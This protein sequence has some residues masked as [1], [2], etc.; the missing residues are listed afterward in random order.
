MAFDLKR[1]LKVMLLASSGPLSVKDSQTAFAR[2]HEQAT[3]LPLTD[4]SAA[5]AAPGETPV[6]GESAGALF[7]AVEDEKYY[8]EVPTFVTAT[9]IREGMETISTEAKASDSELL[10]VE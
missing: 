8:R 6:Q 3:N 4:E 1:V 2:L 7:A 9:Q 5:P 10:L